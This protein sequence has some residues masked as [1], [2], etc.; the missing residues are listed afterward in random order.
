MTK[1]L[2]LPTL[3]ISPEKTFFIIVKVAR[4]FDAKDGVTD[5]E[6]GSNTTR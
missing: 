2:T 3:T 6:S 4:Q 1:I 5:P